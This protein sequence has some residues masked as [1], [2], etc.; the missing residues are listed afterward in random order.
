MLSI[1]EIYWKKY[2]RL[3]EFIDRQINN[4]LTQKKI[5]N[6]N[7]KAENLKKTD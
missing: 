4:L 2:P 5:D 7:N 6:T 1:K 3:I